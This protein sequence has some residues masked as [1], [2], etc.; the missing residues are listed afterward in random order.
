[1]QVCSRSVLKVLLG[2]DARSLVP[3]APMYG[4]ASR[5]AVPRNDFSSGRLQSGPLYKTAVSP[6][7]PLRLSRPVQF[8]LHRIE[9]CRRHVPSG[10]A[11]G[12]MQVV[13]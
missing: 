2:T 12:E 3:I 10:Q 6:T 13:Q 4:R 8:R 9:V 11:T 1:M 5:A 7:R